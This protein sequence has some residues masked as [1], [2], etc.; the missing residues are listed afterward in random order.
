[1]KKECLIRGV[2]PG[3][4]IR[5]AWTEC[6]AMAN[7]GIVTHDTDPAAAEAFANAL[8]AAAAA[9]VMLDQ[10]ERYSIRYDYPGAL[11]G[12]VIEAAADGAVRGFP[13]ENQPMHG[14]FGEAVDLYGA[15]D[16]RIA[17][18]RSGGSGRVLN[19]GQARAPLADPAADLAFFFCVSDQIETEIRTF[20]V[21]QPD[22][23]APLRQMAVLMLQ[24][25]PG[26]DLEIFGRLRSALHCSRMTECRRTLDPALA[27]EDHLKTLLTELASC[28]EVKD[29]DAGQCVLSE[30]PAPHWRC[31]CSRPAM[32][33]AMRVM[34][35]R[36]LEELFDE[37]PNP[38][39]ECQFCR[40]RY[41]F[42]REDF[43]ADAEGKKR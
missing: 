7:T 17:V 29:F 2:H 39:I 4:A 28:A 10:E 35:D 16:G 8:G 9:T 40:T 19:S 22:P 24:A 43:F 26:C 33:R 21:W 14:R 12:L 25:L 30:G 37:R 11:K 36:E 15:K 18:T 6:A 34:G 42:R 3:R 23:E 5:L 38:V 13:L 41:M 20:P 27:P 1:M 31:R 32:A